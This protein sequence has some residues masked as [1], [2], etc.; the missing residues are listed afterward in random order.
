ME[1][2]LRSE[3]GTSRRRSLSKKEEEILYL[4]SL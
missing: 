2:R 1:E 3:R 4:V